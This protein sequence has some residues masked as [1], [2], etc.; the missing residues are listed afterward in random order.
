MIK[1]Y[2]SLTLSAFI[3]TNFFSINIAK[4]DSEQTSKKTFIVTA[5]YSPLPNQSVYLRGSYEEDIKL[6]WAWI[7]WASWKKVFPGMIAAPKSYSF[8][9]KIF[10]EGFGTWSVED[11]WWAIISLNQS[12]SKIDRLDIWMWYGDEWLKRALSWWKRTISGM[13][14]DSWS[15]ISVDLTKF[16]APNSVATNLKEKQEKELKETWWILISNIW[17][18]SN[19]DK[20]K[21]LENILKEMWTFSW[22]VDGNFD[23]ELKE[24]IIKY[25]FSRNLIDSK[26]NLW[27]WYMWPKTRDSLRKDYQAFKKELEEKAKLIKA[28][29]DRKAKQLASKKEQERKINNLV[30]K[31]VEEHV[32]S[33]WNPANWDVS[34]SV[35]KLQQTMKTLGY[36]DEKDTAIFWDKTKQAIIN[37]QIDKW[38]I[39][40]E[41]DKN[42]WKIDNKTLA[43]IKE[44]LKTK[45]KSDIIKQNK[46]VSLNI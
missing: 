44:D 20:I 15:D 21:E 30:Y 29:N 11:R 34:Q 45:L 3:F 28:E 41:K 6:N 1:I 27:A 7:A 22:V 13:I 12:W 4:A 25:Q 18:E 38:I 10:L 24:A 46:L 5:Y 37:Y 17:P 36:F 33:I 26:E 14:V 32:A 23:K 19:P 16:P 42:A 8:W 9:T 2:S 31:K 43:S 39:K 40:N 35:R